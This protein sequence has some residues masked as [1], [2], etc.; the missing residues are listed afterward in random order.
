MVVVV[1]FIGRDSRLFADVF[2]PLPPRRLQVSTLRPSQSPEP[3]HHPITQELLQSTMDR[4]WPETNERNPF[5]AA[6][7]DRG[8]HTVFPRS[9][10]SIPKLKNSFWLAF[11]APCFS[12]SW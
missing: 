5:S 9:T 1:S 6:I 4:F 3:T 11:M 10:I 12:A 7:D 2:F 8:T